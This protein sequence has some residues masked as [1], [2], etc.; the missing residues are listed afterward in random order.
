MARVLVSGDDDPDIYYVVDDAVGPSCANRRDDVMLV[1]FFLRIF[2]DRDDRYR[3]AG[4]KDLAISGVFSDQTAAYLKQYAEEGNRQ[5]KGLMMV[6]S[7][8]R[9]DSPVGSGS[10]FIPGGSGSDWVIIR[11][12]LNYQRW[13]PKTGLPHSSKFPSELRKNF[14]VF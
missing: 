3:P 12:N 11:M 14:Y 1:Q 8:G 10:Q 9:V 5:Q 2:A 6:K 13:F 4:A 7:D